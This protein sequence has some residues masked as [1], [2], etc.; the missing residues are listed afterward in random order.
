MQLKSLT[1]YELLQVLWT[2]LLKKCFESP[3]KDTKADIYVHFSLMSL[4]AKDAKYLK[5]L[6]SH[7]SAFGPHLM[8]Q[9]GQGSANGN[10]GPV[11]SK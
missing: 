5:R 7:S 9:T 11:L 6:R 1:D 10:S 2:V 3:K 4:G 8:R